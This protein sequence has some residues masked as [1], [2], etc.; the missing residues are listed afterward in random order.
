MQKV[1]VKH[2][3]AFSSIPGKGNPAGVVL[4]GNHYTE[5]EM[6]AIAAAVGFN[7]T[8]FVVSS[9]IADFRIRYFTPGHEMNLCGHATMGTVY[10]LRM[11]GLLK[12]SNITIETKAGVLPTHIHEEN[13]KLLITMQ[14]AKP[15][16][17]TFS[18]SKSELAAAIGLTEEDLHSKYPIVYGYTG[19]WTLIVPVKELAS[20]KKMVPATEDFPSVLYEMPKASV[21]PICF[22]VLGEGNDMHARHFSSPFSG[23]IEDAVTGTAS[24]VM[25]AYYKTF[26]NENISLPTTFIVEQGHEMEKDG[27]VYVHVNGEHG[28]LDISISGTA[29]YVKDIEV[30]IE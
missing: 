13:N 23:T 29:V 5:E 24:G 30:E 2:I 8:S 25:G 28:N 18:G 15:Q 21:H 27:L 20:F 7:E 9:E 26:V 11:N 10:A 6:L 16:F 22:E 3:D 12:Q 4:D 14:H 17:Q 1:Y 19:I